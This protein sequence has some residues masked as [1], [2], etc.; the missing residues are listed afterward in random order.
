MVE[1]TIVEIAQV[2]H[3]APSPPHSQDKDPMNVSY[4]SSW[5]YTLS[6][7]VHSHVDHPI[8]LL[9]VVSTCPVIP[10]IQHHIYLFMCLFPLTDHEQLTVRCQDALESLAPGL[11]LSTWQAPRRCLLNKHMSTWMNEPC[12]VQLGLPAESSLVHSTGQKYWYMLWGQER[13]GLNSAPVLTCELN[14][15]E[16]YGLNC[17]SSSVMCHQPPYLRI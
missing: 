14:V 15:D 16:C 6:S 11:A 5:H 3:I 12:Q 10:I 7:N 1:I 17:V 4:Y 8:P 9:N 13:N 2:K